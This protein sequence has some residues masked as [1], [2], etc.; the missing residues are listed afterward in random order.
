MNERRREIASFFRKN[1]HESFIFP[2]YN[3]AH[4]MNWHLFALRMPEGKN[5]D[6]FLNN[7]KSD[8]IGCSVHFIPLY[9]HSCYADSFP[10]A[11]FPQTEAVYQGLFSLPLYPTMTDAEV[12]TVVETANKILLTYDSF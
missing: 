12:E 7:M 4:G 3:P 9:R 10:K 1:L 8:G 2:D 11:D 6:Q 5:R